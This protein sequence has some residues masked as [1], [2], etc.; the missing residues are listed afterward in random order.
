MPPS[1]TPSAPAAPRAA[2]DGLCKAYVPPTTLFDEMEEPAGA[3]RPHWQMFVNLLDDLGPVELERRWDTARQLIH[4]NGVTYNVYGDPAGM[5]RPWHLDAIPMIYGATE[6]AFIEAALTQRARLLDLLLA[7][8]YGPQRLL[9]DGLL[10]PE[11]VFGHRGY[12]RPLHGAHVPAGRWLHFYAADLGRSADG[13]L[14]VIGDRAQAPSGAGYTLEN[15]LVVSRALPDV[16]RDCRVRRL[17]TFFRTF[18]ET[19][20]ALAPH[21][22]ENPRIVLLTPGPY[23]ETYFE[24]AYLARYLGFSLVEGGDLT[25]RDNHVYLKT[26]GGLQQVDVI[27]RRQDDDFCDPLE[28]RADSSLGVPGLVQAVH[29]GNVAV[30]N[31]LGSGILETPALMMYLPN[32]CR[33]LLGEDL[34]L[35]SVGAYWCGDAAARSHVLANL[36]RM[37]IKPTFHHGGY[38]PVFGESLSQSQL[39]EWRD[40]ISACPRD[41]VGEEQITLSTAPVLVGDRVEPRHVVLRTH[42]VATVEP[43][44]RTA[45]AG[46]GVAGGGGGYAVMPGGLT[47]FSASP[48]SMIVSMQRG[49]GSKDAWVLS[50]G[51][52]DTFS[53]LAPANQPVD[54]TRAGGDLPSRVADNLFWL[55]R[56]MER[57][58][59]FARLARG[60][61]ARLT[62]QNFDSSPELPLL[63]A[64][65]RHAASDDRAADADPLDHPEDHLARILLDD[66]FPNGLQA[67]LT[68]IYRIASLVRDRVSVDTWRIIN[69]FD[70]DFPP[71]RARAVHVNDI[72]PALD[73]LIITFAAFGG[74]AMESMTRG[75]A[76]RFLDM[77]RR[78]ER[79]LHTLTLLRGTMTPVVAR[80]A[81][82][83]EAVLEV[84]DSA[85]TYRRR[86][87]TSLQAA[88]V[89]DLLMA[90]ESNPRSVAFQLARLSEHV[91]ALPRPG[92]V[93]GLGRRTLEERLLLRAL[94]NLRLVDMHAEAQP[95][96]ESARRARLDELLRG[97]TTDLLSLSDAL[98]Q[99]Y[100]SHAIATR[101]LASATP[102]S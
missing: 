51:P 95:H 77:G 73:R 62:D 68:S 34:K 79:S 41:Y 81:P 83:L 25:V 90:D 1:H 71:S 45:D 85:M 67:T 82:L 65:L 3:V 55:G 38:E 75:Y 47:R 12:L 56:Y 32:L 22:K 84:A 28:L 97:T 26:L 100:L 31:A 14:W 86:Y 18:R 6:W 76:W 50:G 64:T 33:H 24:H 91:D 30:A 36:H 54:I 43:A 80:E 23:N 42:L 63:L 69:R 102:E 4:D 88:P 53:L 72:L 19:L 27:L 8:L 48:D 96:P 46:G 78:I 15:R 92:A 39:A 52:V 29:S 16:F 60:I 9:R 59:G 98:S 21:N 93:A 87:M 10:P 13:Q 58:E 11:L 94:T 2:S 44:A 7:D 74:L 70:Q 17:A 89:L 40:R 61:T 57:A 35:P 20:K 101:Q 5:D 99:T 66:K 49:G 37:V